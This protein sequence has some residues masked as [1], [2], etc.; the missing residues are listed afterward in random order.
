MFVVL[1]VSSSLR[2][3]LRCSRLFLKRVQVSRLTFYRLYPLIN[4]NPVT[5]GTLLASSDLN[6]VHI[7]R[8]TTVHVAL[9]RNNVL[10][11]EILINLML[12]TP[13]RTENYLNNT[14][15]SV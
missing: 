13:L 10:L 2:P 12:S 9:I 1:Y 4:S 15:Y 7:L 6:T 5:T 8:Q 11:A 3:F 14:T